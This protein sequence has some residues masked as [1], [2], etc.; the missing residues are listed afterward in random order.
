SDD[1]FEAGV[2]SFAAEIGSKAPISMRF[3]KENL[4]AMQRDYGSR[5]V[6]ELDALR[7]CMLSEDWRE[8]V[9]AF[10]EKRAPVFKGR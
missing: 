8:G 9:D 3:A 4:N 7:T 1:E 6:T 5:L 2:A 10:T